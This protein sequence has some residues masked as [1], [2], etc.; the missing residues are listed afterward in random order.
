M[1]KR[2]FTMVETM[3]AAS[4]TSIVLGVLALTYSHMMRGVS[5]AMGSASVVD[6][7]RRFDDMIQTTVQN[8]GSCTVDNSN[9]NP[10]LMCVMPANGATLDAY[11]AYNTYTPTS[12]SGGNTHWGVGNRR[13]F[14]WSNTTGNSTI[15]GSYLWMCETT[16]NSRPTTTGIFPNFAFY[17]GDTTNPR[18]SLISSFTFSVNTANNTVTYTITGSIFLPTN[19]KPGT[20]QTGD[21]TRTRTYSITRTVYW[22][23]STN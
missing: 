14:Y 15:S 8:A 18:W 22:K 6:Q 4:L 10:A 7:V 1:S 3:L 19:S 9:S 13:W 23:H 11:G 12:C 20:A 5:Q 16:S 17:Y 21:S 2:G